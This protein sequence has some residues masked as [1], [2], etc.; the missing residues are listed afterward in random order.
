MSGKNLLHAFRIIAISEGISFLVLLC[1]A[2]PLKYFMDMPLA[3]KI[4]GYIHGFLFI[5]FIL[6]AFVFKNKLHKNLLWFGKAILASLLPFGTFVLDSQLK[7][8]E[9]IL[10]K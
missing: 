8:E 2:M 6:M 9:L 7:K 5:G 3:V 10:N 4:T 1:I